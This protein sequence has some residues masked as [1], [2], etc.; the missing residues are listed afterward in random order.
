[1]KLSDVLEVGVVFA[2]KAGCGLRE[3]READFFDVVAVNGDDAVF[4]GDFAFLVMIYLS[5]E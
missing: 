5:F 4:V 3:A 2:G 1:M